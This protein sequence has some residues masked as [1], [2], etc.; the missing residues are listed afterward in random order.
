LAQGPEEKCARSGRTAGFAGVVICFSP[1]LTDGLVAVG[2]D[3]PGPDM[4][5]IRLRVN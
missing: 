5:R 3:W 4:R 2:G 1:I